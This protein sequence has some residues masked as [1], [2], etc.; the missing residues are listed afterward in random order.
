MTDGASYPNPIWVCRHDTI[1]YTDDDHGDFSLDDA[2]PT[3]AV[4]PTDRTLA[5]LRPL[6]RNFGECATR[7][8]GRQLAKARLSRIGFLRSPGGAVHLSPAFEAGR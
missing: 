6:W 7:V 4:N 3:L 1:P 5:S 8:G 2:R